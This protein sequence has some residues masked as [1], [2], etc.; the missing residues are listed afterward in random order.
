MVSPARSAA[1]EVLTRVL[2]GSEHLHTALV[3]TLGSM[4]L[5]ADDAALATQIAR[6]ATTWRLLL[7][8]WSDA[9]C[10]R[11]GGVRE[12]ALRAVVHA[13]LFQLR[14]L[15]RIP[16]YAAVDDAVELA[17][18][19][20]PAAAGFVNAILR[21][22]TRE[23]PYVEPAFDRDP[24]LMA[25]PVA[26]VALRLS[27]PRWLVRDT[28]ARFGRE[29]GLSILLAGNVRPLQTVRVNGLRSTQDGVLRALAEE[30]VAALPSPTLASS[31]RLSHGGDVTRLNAYAE[32]LFTLQGESSMR[33]APL[34]DPLPGQ[35]L[36]DACA[37]PGGKATHLAELTGDRADVL[38]VDVS[39][40][41]ARAIA[42]Q[43]TRLGLSGVRVRTADV[44][45][46]RS[47]FDGVLLDA[48]CSGIGAIARKPDIKWR[49]S[50][51]DPA[52]LATIQA[53]LLEHVAGCVTAGGRL[54]YAVCTLTTVE[55][56]GVVEAFE[57]RHPE[58]VRDP[59]ADGDAEGHL[60]L[61]PD[62]H[63]GDGF[64]AARFRRI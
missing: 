2:T 38:A 16:D 43:A 11:P 18:R 5:S 37:A 22:A 4:R 59:I 45:R 30:G 3:R 56:H 15:S 21:R 51:T 39:E 44:R 23:R 12:P 54:V 61:L 57:Q 36:L 29:R 14:M 40:V 31:V 60:V 63:T 26:E 42:G 8:H 6:G 62:E 47:A 7:D 9:L 33:I 58:F 27:Y 41:R 64:F 17:K 10:D 1:Q 53:Q 46:V 13:A 34:L 48:L 32:G 52:R 55:T 35:S 24:A 20:T 49:L 28:V 25:A 19:C 50:P